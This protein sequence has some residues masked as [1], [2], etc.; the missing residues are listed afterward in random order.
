VVDYTIEIC[1]LKGGN[2]S[3]IVSQRHHS[4]DSIDHNFPEDFG[5]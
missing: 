4:S 3:S 2:P 5:G 1:D